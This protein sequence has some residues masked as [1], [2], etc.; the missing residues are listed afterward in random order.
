MVRRQPKRSDTR[1]R[2]LEAG[3]Q[4]FLVKGYP[5]TAVDDIVERAGTT[6][7][8][9]YYYFASKQDMARDLQEYLWSS[10]AQQAQD[11]FDPQFDIVTNIKRAFVAHLAAIE[12]LGPE[13]VFLR[14]GFIDPT[15]DSTGLDGFHWGVALVRDLLVDAM[16][17]GEVGHCDPA[18][19]AGLLIEAFEAATLQALENEDV[20]PTLHVVDALLAGLLPASATLPDHERRA[21]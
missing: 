5:A 18:E 21:G 6:R 8:A 17:R 12:E 1:A 14:D 9:F 16:E 13:R 10:I 3:I 15:L 4:A 7:G 2:L 19:A 20:G 11:A